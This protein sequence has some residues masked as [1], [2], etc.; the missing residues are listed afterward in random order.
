MLVDFYFV[1]F[2]AEI[3]QYKKTASESIHNALYVRSTSDIKWIFQYIVIRFF[4][5]HIIIYIYI[6]YTYT[7]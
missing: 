1:E 3:V 4:S 7:A 6:Y 5:I 2:L